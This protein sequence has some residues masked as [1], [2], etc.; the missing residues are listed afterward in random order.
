MH[1]HDA[2]EAPQVVKFTT[3]WSGVRPSGGYNVTTKWKCNKSLYLIN[4]AKGA[5]TRSFNMKLK[6]LIWS[7][8][9]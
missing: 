7:K 9:M 8:L 2:S 5:S 4:T 6:M 3:P 1:D